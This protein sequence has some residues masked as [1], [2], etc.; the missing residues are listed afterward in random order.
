M[1]LPKR[2]E[3]LLRT[4]FALPNASSTGFVRTICSSN[5]GCEEAS[6][7]YIWHFII[8]P[9]EATAF[10]WL[11][12]TIAKYDITFFVFSVLPAPDS[13]VINID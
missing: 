2:D 10:V 6:Y 8:T 13:P 7:A 11:A 4:V 1:N 12:P 3:L 5:D 9:F